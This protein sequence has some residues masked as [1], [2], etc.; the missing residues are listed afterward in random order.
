MRKKTGPKPATKN[1][2]RAKRGEAALKAHAWDSGAVWKPGTEADCYLT[3]L[4]ADLMHWCQWKHL[5][6]FETCYRCA[7]NHFTEEIEG[8]DD[9]P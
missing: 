9:T 7:G 1:E 8:R 3:D 4:L 5:A 6:D 2:E